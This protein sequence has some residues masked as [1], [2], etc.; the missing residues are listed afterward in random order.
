MISQHSKFN[1]S[2][3][4]IYQHRTVQLL[5]SRHQ[6]WET[7]TQILQHP[8]LISRRPTNPSAHCLGVTVWA[9]KH[10]SAN[11]IMLGQHCTGVSSSQPSHRT[12]MNSSCVRA[13]QLCNDCCIVWLPFKI[14]LTCK[15][16]C[17]IRGNGSLM[18]L[19]I[20]MEGMLQYI[21]NTPK[22]SLSGPVCV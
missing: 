8:S 7:S 19:P 16:T 1:I 11:K 6:K 9:Q 12:V 18:E 21:P 3:E 14:M 4:F 5:I 22:L 10:C 13:S 17:Q 2:P 20:S 15:N